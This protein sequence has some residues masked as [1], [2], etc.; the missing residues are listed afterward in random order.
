MLL[1]IE[2]ELKTSQRI[3]LRKLCEQLLV[4]FVSKTDDNYFPA[5]FRIP[6]DLWEKWVEFGEMN[7]YTQRMMVSACALQYL[8]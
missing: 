5:L 6:K 1:R 4:L 8:F 3:I 7:T 2:I